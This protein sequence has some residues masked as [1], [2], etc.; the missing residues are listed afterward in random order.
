R[1]TD[2]RGRSSGTE[3]TSGGRRRMMLQS[4]RHETAL[5]TGAAGFIGGWLVRALAPTGCRLV[6]VE[7][8]HRTGFGGIEGNHRWVA[9]DLLDA[10][11]VKDLLRAARPTV[12]FHLAGTRGRGMANA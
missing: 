12:L 10:D 1:R 9:A 6:L 5:V 3:N 11:S 7:H 8:C 2:W 4:L